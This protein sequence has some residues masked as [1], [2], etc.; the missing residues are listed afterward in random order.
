MAGAGFSPIG[1]LVWVKPYA[2]KEQFVRYYHEQA[3]LLAKGAP[4]KP[5][6][7]LP[8]VLDWKYTGNEAHPTQKPVMA[9]LP[10]IMATRPRATWCLIRSRAPAR[11]LW[12]RRN[13]A[14][15]ISGLT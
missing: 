6:L 7:R 14:G 8:D 4:A 3:Y 9:I 11:R 10:L 5:R 12:Q 13:C 2:S 15:D 1:H